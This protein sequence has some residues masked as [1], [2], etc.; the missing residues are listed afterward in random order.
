MSRVVEVDEIVPGSLLHEDVM[1]AQGMVLLKKGITLEEKHTKIL[2]RWG[3]KKISVADAA[4]A[5]EDDRDPE[6]VIAEKTAAIEGELDRKFKDV[7]SN[8]IMKEL[9]G[10]VKTIRIDQMKAKYQA[11]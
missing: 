7:E 3:V 1:N 10:V 6:E 4:E 9:K 2:K 5:V 8:E 11:K